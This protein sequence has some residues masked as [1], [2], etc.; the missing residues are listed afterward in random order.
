MGFHPDALS[1]HK[2]KQVDL[3][4]DLFQK[5]RQQF[6]SY[7]RTHTKYPLPMKNSSEIYQVHIHDEYIFSTGLFTKSSKMKKQ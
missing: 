5:P 2:V 6:R 3:L 7:M 4:R 1:P